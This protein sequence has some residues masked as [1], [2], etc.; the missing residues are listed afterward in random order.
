[1]PSRTAARRVV[2]SALT[3]IVLAL[4]LGACTGGDAA[5]PAPPEATTKLAATAPADAT[6]TPTAT[7]RPALPTPTPTAGRE[8]PTPAPPPPATPTLTA[9]PV[10]PTPAPAA[11]ATPVLPDVTLEI[12]YPNLPDGAFGG[13]P[14]FLTFPPD[15]SNRVAV[16][17]QDG[18]IVIFRNDPGVAS[19]STFLDIRDRVNRGGNEEGLLGLAFHPQYADN[20]F[21]F[22]YY[23][24][25]SPR[26]SVL[27]RFSV[28]GDSNAADPSSESVLLEIEEP[29]SN[30]NGGMLAFGPDGMLYVAVG[31][32][33]SRADPQG[34]GQNLATLL[35][36][37]LRI[38]V[39]AS[40]QAL[41]YGIPPDN[42]FAG[43]G[44]TQGARGEIWAY[45]LRNPWRF[46]FDRANGQLWVGDV[47][48]NRR[49]EIDLVQRGGNYGWNV[50]EGNRC[51]SP[52]SGCNQQ[53]LE[54]PVIDYDHDLGCSVTGGYVYRGSRAPALVGAYVYADFCSGT[55]WALRHQ[56]GQVVAQREI[57]GTRLRI[58]SFGEDASGELYVLAFDGQVYRL[59]E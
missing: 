46:S 12:A 44:T 3:G 40:G 34:N 58:S 33:G 30:H 39:D 54:L 23:S 18:V 25:R 51:F 20:G 49:E 38:D 22:V 55:I 13:R 19:V 15:G 36:S 14:L 50:M 17:S 41:G 43:P 32:G 56:G 9:T 2:L 4:A 42:P 6:P 28:T 35:G 37:I 10:P 57:A 47:G 26:R 21:F 59:A 8:P 52:S 31:D 7:L 48:Q 29:F 27:S 45:G 5:T 53:G 11:T 1:M 24:A 16:V